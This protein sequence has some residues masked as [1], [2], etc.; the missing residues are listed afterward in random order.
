MCTVK[1]PRILYLGNSCN[2][3]YLAP[4]MPKNVPY[5]GEKFLDTYFF[6]TY[7]I[8]CRAYV[9]KVFPSCNR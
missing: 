8:N 9:M 5:T 1:Y 4:I 2:N 6:S 3:S 7:F